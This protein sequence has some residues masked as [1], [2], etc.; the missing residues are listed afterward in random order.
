MQQVWAWDPAPGSPGDFMLHGSKGSLCVYVPPPA[1]AG[2]PRSDALADG[3]CSSC[4]LA[5]GHIYPEVSLPVT[6]SVTRAAQ[7]G[8]SWGHSWEVEEW[9]MFLHWGDK[10]AAERAAQ[11]RG[12]VMGRGPR[13]APSTLLGVCSG[14]S[15]CSVGA[16]ENFFKCATWGWSGTSNVHDTWS[17]SLAQVFFYP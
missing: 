4:D 11:V 9:G 2:T 3:V 7:L 17:G 13:A 15:P 16:V 14:V 1:H 10:A 5:R 6:G 12:A 8:G